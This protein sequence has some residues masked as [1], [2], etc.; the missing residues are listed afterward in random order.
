MLNGVAIFRK[1]I[2]PAW[3]DPKNKKGGDFSA[4][5]RKTTREIMKKYWDRIILAIIGGA[6]KYADSVR[7]RI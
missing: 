3:E 4:L 7:N 1:G 5:L 2:D 6:W